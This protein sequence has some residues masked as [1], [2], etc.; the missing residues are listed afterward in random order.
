MVIM[1]ILVF[2]FWSVL[3]DCFSVV[4]FWEDDFFFLESK[5]I[6][7]WV[8]GLD[9]CSKELVL[10]IVRWVCFCLWM[11]LEELMVFLNVDKFVCMLE[12]FDEVLY[13]MMVVWDFFGVMFRD[14]VMD[15]INCFWFLKCKF[16]IDDDVFMRKI[17]LVLKVLIILKFELF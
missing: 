3:K 1:N 10:F 17:M 12:W 7:F 2:E 16:L 5:I 11:Y 9:V 6:I 14:F 15:F 13:V 8:F 4:I